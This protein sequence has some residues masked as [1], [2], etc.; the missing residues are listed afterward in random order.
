MLSASEALWHLLGAR[1][2]E[3]VHVHVNTPSVLL[4]DTLH[5]N[6]LRTPNLTQ[7]SIYAIFKYMV[8]PITTTTLALYLVLRQLLKGSELLNNSHEPRTNGNAGLGDASEDDDSATQR[9]QLS[10]LTIEPYRSADIELLTAS[11]DGFHTASWVPS[12][13]RL[14][15]TP[16]DDV[17]RPAVIVL[18]NILSISEILTKIALS[19]DAKYCAVSTSAGRVVIWDVQQPSAPLA[20]PGAEDSSSDRIVHLFAQ[21][22]VPQQGS[23]PRAG[24]SMDRQD[25]KAI[26]IA[27]RITGQVECWRV[28]KRRF[29]KAYPGLTSPCRTEVLYCSSLSYPVITRLVGATLEIMAWQED[30]VKYSIQSKLYL[31]EH[32]MPSSQAICSIGGR[33]YLAMGDR[34]GN[35]AIWDV[36]A[37]DQLQSI[38][39]HVEEVRNIRLAC[40]ALPYCSSCGTEAQDAIL[41]TSSSRLTL[42]AD[43]LASGTFCNCSHIWGSA[44]N[45]SPS[46]NGLGAPNGSNRVPSPRGSSADEGKPGLAYPLSPHA[47]RRLSHAGDRKKAEDSGRP[48]NGV[49]SMLPKLEEDV[50]L[51]S[52][53]TSL[54]TSEGGASHRQQWHHQHIGR[55]T[56][57]SRISWDILGQRIVGVRRC[58][59]PSSRHVLARWETWTLLL[60]KPFRDPSGSLLPHSLSVLQLLEAQKDKPSSLHQQLPFDRIQHF[61]VSR[62]GRKVISGLGNLIVVSTPVA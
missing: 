19:D 21:S 29:T 42:S 58:R 30:E 17:E 33:L 23:P 6:V 15:V 48:L 18:R 34:I 53:D 57:D 37:G 61:F 9:P 4:F 25:G 24:Q 14:L 47:L 56:I 62:D 32:S 1:I 40:F 44:L 20:M 50:F 27:V 10:C 59:T 2:S 60:D 35:I 51:H 22:H 39:A 43:R 13:K 16:A 41:L 31:P 7:A 11:R 8:V 12:E 3:A 45:R 46:N 26:F 54:A 28:D 49:E 52:R 38:S 55:S 36:L 5:G